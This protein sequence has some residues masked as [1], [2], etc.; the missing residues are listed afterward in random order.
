MTYTIPFFIHHKYI[1]D[2]IYFY[3]FYLLLHPNF[4]KKLS[5]VYQVTKTDLYLYRTYTVE[6][7]MRWSDP[8]EIRLKQ[9]QAMIRLKKDALDDTG[10]SLL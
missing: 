8:V 2:P 5:V 3:A 9:I 6:H 7:K 10:W 4:F 1:I